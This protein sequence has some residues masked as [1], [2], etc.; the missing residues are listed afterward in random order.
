M[1]EKLAFYMKKPELYEPGDGAFWND[2]HISA[3]MLEAHL[4]PGA[5]GATRNHAFVE[6]SARWIGERYPSSRCPCLLDLGCGPGIYGRHFAAGGYAVTGVDCSERSIGYAVSH[7]AGTETYLCADYL[8]LSFENSF[9]LAVMIW[10]DYGV[11]SPKDRKKVL[12]NVFRALKPGGV[13]LLDVF[14]AEKFDGRKEH[15][16]YN[17]EEQGGFWSAQPYLLL[18]RVWRY[19]ERTA[20]DR[21][22][23]VTAESIRAVNIWEHYFTAGELRRELEDAGFRQ[24]GLWSDVAGK[25]WTPGSEILC[26][27]VRKAF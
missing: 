3:R 16:S 18:S 13:F 12:A 1:F 21:H 22:I 2:S 4:D 17:W 15:T 8:G 10:C 27:A 25:T 11:L 23:V 7:R 6:K 5:D 26:T 19:R 20:L 9:D 14:G 24:E